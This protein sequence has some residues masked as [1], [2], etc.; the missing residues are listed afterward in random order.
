MKDLLENYPNVWF[1]A[2]TL[3]CVILWCCY[4]GAVIVLWCVTKMNTRFMTPK[5][6]LIWFAMMG[7]GALL[8]MGIFEIRKMIP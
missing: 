5:V 3:F 4:A 1:I 6:A 2:F 8:C 7:I